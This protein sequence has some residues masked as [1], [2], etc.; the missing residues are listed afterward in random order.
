MYTYPISCLL[1][2]KGLTT[3]VHPEDQW[4]LDVEEEEGNF[5]AVWEGA[6]EEVVACLQVALALLIL[7]T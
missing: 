5:Q 2:L 4:S 3:T 1:L 6:E 7:I